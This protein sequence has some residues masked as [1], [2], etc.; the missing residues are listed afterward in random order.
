MDWVYRIREIMKEQG[1]N[2]NILAERLQVE[3]SSLSKMMRSDVRLSTLQR[4][5]HALGVPVA[6]L[7]TD[8][9]TPKKADTPQEDSR[10]NT[11]HGYLRIGNDIIEIRSVKELREALLLCDANYMK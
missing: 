9:E 6:A 4:M 3:A 1:V 5:A 7:L 11:I 10:E 8:E 2:Q